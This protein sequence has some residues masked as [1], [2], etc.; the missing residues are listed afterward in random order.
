MKY[1]KIF[2][3]ESKY[4]SSCIICAID[5]VIKR[6]LCKSAFWW[7]CFDGKY[8]SNCN[9]IN[10]LILTVF[11]NYCTLDQL[12]S[13]HLKCTSCALP[14]VH[15]SLMIY[16]IN[17]NLQFSKL[18]F[19]FRFGTMSDGNDSDSSD[20]FSDRKSQNRKKRIKKKASKSKTPQE[21][22]VLVPGGIIL[23]Q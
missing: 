11:V 20:G 4:G 6:I 1:L 12:Q 10:I 2:R 19:L 22:W 15:L 18:F 5:V 23:I 17:L 9:Y 3:L 7:F 21:K 16:T 13:L 8:F 14:V